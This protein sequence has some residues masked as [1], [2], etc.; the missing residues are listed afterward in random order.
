MSGRRGILQYSV[1]IK[2]EAVRL[3]LEDHLSYREVAVQTC[4]SQIC[5]DQSMGSNV[6]ICIDRKE[7]HPFMS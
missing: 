6:S 5:T 2:Q 3:V 1:E 7:S 4:N